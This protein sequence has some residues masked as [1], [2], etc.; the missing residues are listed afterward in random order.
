MYENAIAICPYCGKKFK[1]S[2]TYQKYC[3]IKCRRLFNKNRIKVYPSEGTI[4]RS[5]TC[6]CCGKIVCVYDLK[7][8]RTKFCS[9]LCMKRWFRHPHKHI[10]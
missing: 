10:T 8:R 5:F 3:C 7:D 1:K 2:Y 6:K 9:T 4:I